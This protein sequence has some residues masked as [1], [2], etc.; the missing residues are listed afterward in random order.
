MIAIKDV[1][2]MDTNYFF[3]LWHINNN[4]IVNCKK[5]FDTKKTWA[6]DFAKQ[7]SIV[8]ILLEQEFLEI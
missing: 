8:Y 3:C 2:S 7:K 5:Y 4:V 1:F 6:I